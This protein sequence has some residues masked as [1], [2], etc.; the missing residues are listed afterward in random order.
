MRI[1]LTEQKVTQMVVTCR[2]IQEK[3]CLSVWELAELIGKLTAAFPTIFPVP[4]WYRELKRLKNQAIRKD[5]SFEGLVRL[6]QE[7]L[8]E[9]QWWSTKMNLM[10]GKNM[11]TQDQGMVVETDASMLGWGTHCKGVQ[12]G[13][14]GLRQSGEITKIT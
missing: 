7:A 8:L 1:K 13:A 4:L 3:Q 14:C 5:Q 12:T 6:N 10:N 11:F 9:L 2:A